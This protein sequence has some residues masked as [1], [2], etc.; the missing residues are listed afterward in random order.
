ALTVDNGLAG[1]HAALAIARLW[2]D[3]DWAAAEREFRKALTMN[4][5]NATAHEY[6][7]EY[8]VAMG[9]PEEAIAEYKRARDLEPLSLDINAQF[10]RV[11][12][13]ARRYDEAID[14]CRK[15]LELDPNFTMAH[16]CLELAYVGKRMY[17][18]AITEFQK[19]RAAGG[20]PCE[21]AAL[22]YTYAVAGNR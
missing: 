7:A 22:G 5:N 18:E 6:F 16:W 3:W 14:Q 20:C 13:D 4:P 15:T 9:R 8:F 11:Y 10:G 12:R 17:R 21:L 19:A 1:A 2:F